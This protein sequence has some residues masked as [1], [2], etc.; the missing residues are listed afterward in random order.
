MLEPA[1]TSP[2]AS[3]SFAAPPFDE[4]LAAK[5]F[6]ANAA[7]TKS[8]AG[9]KCT[10]EESR[11][12]HHTDPSA[13]CENERMFVA[14]FGRPSTSSSRVQRLF[15]ASFGLATKIPFCVPRHNHPRASASKNVTM[16]VDPSWIGR[17]R[18]SVAF[19]SASKRSNANDERLRSAT[20]T[21]PPG[22]AV[23]GP[24]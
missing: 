11:V 17:K 15:S 5:I 8:S 12:D 23:N 21:S 24:Q 19:P 18:F 16:P 4:K 6:G 14:L 1:G 7:R 10:S 20:H 2:T 3:A 22:K 13:S 9:E